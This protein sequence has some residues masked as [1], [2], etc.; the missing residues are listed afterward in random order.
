MVQPGAVAAFDFCAHA[1]GSLR[2]T[3]TGPAATYFDVLELDVAGTNQLVGAVPGMVFQETSLVALYPVHP[4]D[5]ARMLVRNISDQPR[6]CNV[7]FLVQRAQG[8]V[9]A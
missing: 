2:V 9:S 3:I 5:R 8:E 4:G 6:T 7:M 1:S